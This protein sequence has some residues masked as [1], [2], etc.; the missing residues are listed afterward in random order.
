MRNLIILIALSLAAPASAQTYRN[1]TNAQDTL[2]AADAR[3]ARA[4]DVTVTND[5][6]VLQ[7]SA[8]TE[9]ALRDV[10][11]ARV[12]PPAVAVPLDP[13]AVPPK[14]DLSQMVEI[15]DAALAASTARARAAA[16][17]RR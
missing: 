5:L 10:A 13:K 1:L 6:S 16:D 14:L 17:N 9:Q 12:A 2:R 4:R 8:R 15:P 7:A 11:S 3:A